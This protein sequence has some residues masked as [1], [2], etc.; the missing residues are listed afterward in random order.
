MYYT[1]NKT[2]LYFCCLYKMQF[3]FH[4]TKFEVDNTQKTMSAVLL[5]LLDDWRTNWQ[6]G[7][8]TDELVVWLVVDLTW[9]P[10]SS[11]HFFC[12]SSYHTYYKNRCSS[13]CTLLLLV[14][15]CSVLR[16]NGY[17]CGS[18]L[19]LLLVAIEIGENILYSSKFPD[20]IYTDLCHKTRT[21]SSNISIKNKRISSNCGCSYENS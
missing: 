8:L 13:E 7:W 3:Q 6:T 12:L 18:L 16:W 14:F 2:T 4:N 17:D 9:P 1:Y 19:L 11:S 20:I 10:N 15:A 5:L 21:R